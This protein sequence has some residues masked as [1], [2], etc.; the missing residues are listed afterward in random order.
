MIN[1]TILFLTHS[2]FDIS[3]LKR[4][5]LGLGP[6]IDMDA[7]FEKPL[8]KIFS[9]VLYYDVWKNYATIGV[10]ES[11]R[12]ILQIVS[13]ERPKYV[14]W[15]TL[16]YEL[17]ETTLATIRSKGS[18]VLGWFSD[19]EV[20]FD[21]YSRWWIPYLDFV[22]TN[23]KGSIKKY[24][25]IGAA[26]I[27]AV[28]GS[29]PDIFKK[30]NL[31]TIYDISFVGK[32]FGDRGLW[33]DQLNRIGININAYGNG[34]NAGYVTTDEM[35]NI[36]NSSKINLCFMQS[37]GINTRPQFKTRIFEVCMCGGFLLCEYVSGIEDYFEPDKEIVCFHDLEDAKTK[38]QYYLRN[39][40][41]RETI[42]HAG[43]VRSKANYSQEIMLYRIFRI[44]EEHAA[45]KK[46]NKI[47]PSLFIMPQNVRCLPA[48]FHLNWARG[49]MTEGYPQKRWREELD[50][51]LFYDPSNKEAL[52]LRLIG[53]LP[54]SLRRIL[55]Y[56]KSAY[57]K[58]KQLLHSSLVSIP[59]L[60]KIK[61]ALIS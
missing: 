30:L 54:L 26:A 5:G 43:W 36:F 47:S 46:M 2:D 22:L 40:K 3:D 15:H 10:G 16:T 19:D 58:L 13:K 12:Q 17:L 53:R 56:C 6:H 48:Q 37:Y 49:L 41:E 1:E 61:R 52:R 7:I 23:D 28:S 14:L 8:K 33:V 11:N 31:P 27:H 32:K 51:A 60:R 45:I 57:I 39:D 21:D 18:L 24:E 59:M 50:L 34:W 35:V 9:K 20:R 29:N 25:G 4:H 55:L 44:V 42:A 38:I